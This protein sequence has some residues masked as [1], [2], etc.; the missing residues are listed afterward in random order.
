MGRPKQ[1][2]PL[3]NGTLVSHAV[4][5]A[6]GAGCKPVIVVVGAQPDVVQAALAAKPV[7]IV[8]NTNW[9]SGMGSSICA[10]VKLHQE[11]QAESAAV[12]ILLADQPLITADHV[13][14]MRRLL[15]SSGASVVA[16][17][18]NGTVGVPAIFTRQMLPQLA[19]LHGEGGAKLLLRDPNTVRFTLAEAAT[20][21]DTPEDFAALDRHKSD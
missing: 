6:L 21:I 15:I 14:Q 5:V 12:V 9:Q 3:G 1:V 8:R 13:V 2:L 16:A 7:E 17:E 4:D 20:D 18:Y 19:A 11:L 10:G